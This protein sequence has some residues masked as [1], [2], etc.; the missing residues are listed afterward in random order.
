MLTLRTEDAV[1]VPAAAVQVS[2]QGTFVYVVADGTAHVR[3]VK[4]AR[5][6]GGETVL[7]SGL[8]GGETVVTD[9]HLQLN[10]GTRV[11]P[12]TRQEAPARKAGT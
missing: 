3:P 10:D 12:R 6:Q 4:V 5:T 8:L 1:T 7:E 2:Q 11:N 9:G